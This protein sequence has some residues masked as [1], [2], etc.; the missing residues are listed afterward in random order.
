MVEK[1]EI[2]EIIDPQTR[3]TK[4]DYRLG[5]PS[6]PRDA[7]TISKTLVDQH[8]IIDISTSLPR[9]KT[10]PAYLR[11]APPH[12][13]A[14]ISL[15]AWCVQLGG[16]ADVP[17]GRARITCFWSWNPKG[18]WAVGGG[19]PQHLPSSVVGLVDHIREG[20]EKVPVLLGYGADVS[21]GAMEYDTTR[22]TL[23]VGYAIINPDTLEEDGSRRKIEFGLSSTES[24]DVQIHVKTQH[25]EDSSSAAWTSFVGRAPSLVPDGTAPKRL[26]LRFSHA[27]LEANE[28]LVRA[29]V[30]IEQT[31]TSTTPNVRLNGIPVN[32]ESMEQK[33][34]ESR[35]VLQETASTS[36]VSLKTISTKRSIRS[37]DARSVT[38]PGERERSPS[39]D[40]TIAALVRRNYIYFTSLLQEPEAKWRPVLDSRGVAIHQLD[41]IDR[42]LIVYRA[43]AVFVGVGIW[44]LF[45]TIASPGGRLIWDKTH[46]QATLLEDVNELT[47]LWHFRSRAAWPVAAR[48]SILLRTTYKSPSSVHIFGF[49][50][51]NTDLFPMIPPSIDANVIR[52]QVDLQG[53]SIESLSP[54]TTQVT[55]LEQSDPRGWSNKSSIPQVMMSTLA[56]IG[57]FAIKHGAPPVA[58][59]LGGAKA[60]MSKYDVEKETYRF[61]YRAAETR[62]SS[63]SSTSTAFPLPVAVKMLNGDG[64][65]ASTKSIEIPAQLVSNIECELRCDAETWSNSY[66]I[67]V[68]PPQ[69]GISAL[70]RSKLSPHGGGL[71]LTIEHDSTTVRDEKIVII[72]RRGVAPPTG[73]VSVQVNG[74]KIKVDLEELSEAEVGLLKKQKRSRPTRAPLDQPPALGTLRKKQSQMDINTLSPSTPATPE[75]NTTYSKIASPLTK[76]YSY[77]AESTRAAIVP[78]ATTSPSPA[79]GDTPVDAAVKALGQLMRMHGDRDGESTDPNGWQAVTERDGL[80]IEKRLVSHVSDTFPVYRAGRIIEGFTA[81]EI[82]ACVSVSR[83]DDRFDAP[84]LIQSYGQ[85]ISTS[86]VTAYTT[87][88][89]R[90][91]SILTANITARR[92]DGPPSSPFTERPSTLS[93]IF[94]ASS[95]SFDPL[96]LD[97]DPAKYNPTNLSPAHVLLEGWILETIDPYSHEQYAIPS[98]RCMY[99]ACVDYSGNLPMSINNL[100]NAALPR[101]MLSVEQ[102]L[103]AEGPPCRARLPAICMTTPEASSSGPWAVSSQDETSTGITQVNRNSQYALSII[104]QPTNRQSD[105]GLLTPV[106]RHNDSHTSVRSGQSTIVDLGE[107]VRRGKRDLTVAE[108]ELSAAFVASGCEIATLAVSLPIAQNVLGR[109]ILP[110]ELPPDTID[111]PF[112]LCIVSIAPPVSLDPGIQTR[113]L[114]RVTLPTSGYEAPLHDPLSSRASPL[115]RPRWLLDLINDGAVVQMSLKPRIEGKGYRYAMQ[116]VAVIDEPQPDM[117]SLGRRQS[118]RLVNVDTP[119]SRSLARP[120]AVSKDMLKEAITIAPITD[121]A[122]ELGSE[123]ASTKDTAEGVSQPI[124]VS[125]WFV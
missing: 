105:G 103:K 22:I 65:A 121:D 81:E 90:S 14:H 120:L 88:P 44:D 80:R 66:S 27:A 114:L 109:N 84:E 54:N 118:P 6:N 8:T 69:I 112:K 9:S 36:A 59:R 85:G 45:A 91:R 104:L 111:L 108:I 124:K 94:H 7:V 123:V 38:R 63:S 24:W 31:A 17:L 82:S 35:P 2:L 42:T 16:T 47:D 74:H 4:T 19:V 51:D 72:V 30:T 10:E 117:G 93:T 95:S 3:V 13:R 21:I 61:E 37:Q 57:E 100:L 87:F 26:I 101:V 56:G 18:A 52:T 5:W 67:I 97:A 48:D 115:P 75:R 107:E 96:V 70:K 32:I 29:N 99:V 68:D 116:E 53:W 71:W 64:D 79:P 1:A 55:L 76:M 41:S 77:A 39:A 58:T 122:T 50:T 15:L 28:E 86:H 62:R 20:S 43:E 119:G 46:E 83:R 102:R 89:F 92:A 60:L 11:P 34:R 12:V 73:K 23:A 106:L 78:M 25:G 125:L 40:K 113:H 49:S 110:F 98:T 33:R